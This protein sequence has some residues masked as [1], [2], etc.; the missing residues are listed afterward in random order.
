[1]H[2]Y[3]RYVSTGWLPKPAPTRGSW[4]GRNSNYPSGSSVGVE[5]HSP[6]NSFVLLPSVLETLKEHKMVCGRE[7]PG[8]SLQSPLRCKAGSMDAGMDLH[9]SSGPSAGEGGW[10]TRDSELAGGNVVFSK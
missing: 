9:K 4:D 1:M 3:P 7:N 10:G 2:Q 6:A 8:T 5:Q